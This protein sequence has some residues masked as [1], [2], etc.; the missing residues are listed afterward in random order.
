MKIEKRKTKNEKQKMKNEKW[1][2][3]NKKWKMKNE[4]RNA[5]RKNPKESDSA[6]AKIYIKQKNFFFTVC[7]DRLV[8]ERAVHA[9]NI[10]NRSRVRI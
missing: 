10:F 5:R 7:S 8:V 1:K 4:K 2:M 3:K 9:R 6:L